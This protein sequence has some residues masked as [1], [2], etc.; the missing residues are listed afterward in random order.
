MMSSFASPENTGTGAWACMP[1]TARCCIYYSTNTA[2]DLLLL[3]RLGS[4][5]GLDIVLFAYL[6]IHVLT[7]TCILQYFLPNKRPF[8]PEKF[9]FPVRPRVF[10]RGSCTGAH[11]GAAW[12]VRCKRWLRPG[13]VNHALDG[14]SHESQ[15][16][17]QGMGS[18]F[19]KS[20]QGLENLP[21]SSYL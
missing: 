3:R 19:R 13:S 1:S 17:S 11:R 20:I 2:R 14:Q 8:F 6:H 16:A 4:G 18:H 10:S 15:Q 7:H 5:L 21:G 9:T 12:T